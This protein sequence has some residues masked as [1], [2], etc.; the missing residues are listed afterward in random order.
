MGTE[1]G[2]LGLVTDGSAWSAR[3]LDTAP[4]A[5]RHLHA[6]YA[7]AGATVHTANTFRTTR[8]GVGDRARELTHRAVAL[9]RAAVPSSHR[10]AG[11]LAPARDCYRPQD[12]PPDAVAEDEHTE[13][14][15]HLAEA[16][17]DLI[18]CETF[19]DPGETAIA[20]RAA[21]ATGLETWVALT[22]GYRLDLSDPPR[23]GRLAAA[24]VDL[25]VARVLV[26]CVPAVATTR[27]VSAISAVGVPFGA[28][29]NAG[30]AEDG[31]GWGETEGPARYAALAREWVALGATAV[32]GCC[33]TSPDHVRALRE[34]LAG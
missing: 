1:L 26:N 3:V 25:G 30:A 2:R 6:A 14:A 13:H 29:A 15:A 22:A 7:H 16:G 11:S 32:G 28:Y 33:G 12:R 10:I 4:H 18:L 17:V 34:T 31:L 19:S 27:F 5:I 20:V 21:L 24:V 23:L 8:W 9:A